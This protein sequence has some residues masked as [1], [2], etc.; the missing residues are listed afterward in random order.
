MGKS[1]DKDLLPTV[2]GEQ[3][4]IIIYHSK[5]GK[6]NVA[7]MSRDGNVWLNQQQIATLF[8][9]SIPNIAMHVA[10]ILKEGELDATSV[11][12]QYLTTASDGKEYD[13]TSTVS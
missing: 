10:K 6:I 3:N 2:S 5:D 12:K 9:T 7:L 4:D 13:V 1:L 8:G 11:I